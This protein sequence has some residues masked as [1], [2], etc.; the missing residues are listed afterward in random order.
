M[1]QVFSRKQRSVNT[2][3]SPKW[4]DLTIRENKI[5]DETT[6]AKRKFMNFISQSIEPQHPSA[7][8]ESIMLILI[9]FP[10]YR[11]PRKHFLSS[12]A[13]GSAPI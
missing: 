3:P 2:I 9:Y 12:G 6:R 4:P 13:L 8:D 11:D 1:K 10:T 5:R 7:L